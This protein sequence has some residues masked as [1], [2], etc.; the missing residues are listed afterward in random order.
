[1]LAE[2]V[3][4]HVKSEGKDGAFLLLD[5]VPLRSGK[6]FFIAITANE[7]CGGVRRGDIQ[8]V[9]RI[10]LINVTSMITAAFR[11]FVDVAV[12]APAPYLVQLSA[13]A[14]EFD[15]DLKAWAN[16]P[17]GAADVD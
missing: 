11:W 16:K 15:L 10:C 2:A 8:P 12:D 6:P 9:T 17:R 3:L 5:P 14:S 13:R 4:K 1:M 7:F